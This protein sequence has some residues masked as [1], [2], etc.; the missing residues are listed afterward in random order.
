MAD[1]GTGSELPDSIKKAWNLF[2]TR[3]ATAGIIKDS[4]PEVSNLH[5]N[6]ISFDVM[7]FF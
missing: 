2:L 4:P 3:Q 1:L 7:L 5:H 6:G